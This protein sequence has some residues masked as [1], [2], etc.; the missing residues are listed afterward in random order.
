MITLLENHKYSDIFKE[1]TFFIETSKLVYREVAPAKFMMYNG[2]CCRQTAFLSYM[3]LT[4][5]IPEYEW[6]IYESTF[7]SVS[8]SFEHSWCYGYKKGESKLDGI[9]VDLAYTGEIMENFLLEGPNEFP[10]DISKID[11]GC[12]EIKTKRITM[13]PTFYFENNEFYTGFKGDK[14]YEFIDTMVQ[15]RKNYINKNGGK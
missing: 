10:G 6:T 7:K 5:Y 13:S 8:N 9:F 12:R 3:F 4:K 14:L 15:E 2:N 1:L 11:A